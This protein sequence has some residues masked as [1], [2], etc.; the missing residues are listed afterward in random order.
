MLCMENKEVK[1]KVNKTGFSGHIIAIFIFVVAIIIYILLKIGSFSLSGIPSLASINSYLEIFENSL[2]V[3]VVFSLTYLFIKSTK[4]LIR[5]H[6]E[7][8]GRSKKNIKLFLTV[9]GYFAWLIVIFLT[10]SLVFKQIG[11]LVTSIGLIG[12]GL[13]LALQKPILNFVGWTT[14]IFGKTYHIGDIISMNNV[15]GRVYDI[16]VMYTSLSELNSD[17]DSTGRAVTIPNEFVFIHPVINFSKGTDYI[18]DNIAIYL[19]YKSNWKKAIKIVEKTV[20]EYYDKNIKKEIE[21]IFKDNFKEYDKIIVRFGV[22]EKGFY[23]KARYM[24]DFNKANE[25]KREL[26]EL[27]LEKI[28]IKDIFLGKVEN[29]A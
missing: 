10:F 25:I 29:V 27:L 2:I 4:R 8:L 12:F 17:G 11:S 28:N 26:T 23:I 20:Q 1:L 6:L 24:V 22:Y 21:K 9:Y 15:I 13:T 14:I 7:K 16:R 3:L 5:N 18:W 19:T